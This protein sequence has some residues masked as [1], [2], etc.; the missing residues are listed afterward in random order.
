MSGVHEHACMCMCMIVVCGVHVC[1]CMCVS[2]V[3]VNMHV[4]A[5]V[6]VWSVEPWEWSNDVQP[7]LTFFPSHSE[8][9]HPYTSGLG[10]QAKC[11]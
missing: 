3:C 1:V 10:H 8:A 9:S 7:S 6:L 2:V 5:G 4:C 11:L